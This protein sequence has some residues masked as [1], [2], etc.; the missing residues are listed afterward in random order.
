MYLQTNL[1]HKYLSSLENCKWNFRWFQDQGE[2]TVFANFCNLLPFKCFWQCP[3]VGEGVIKHRTF[4]S[5]HF[6]CK[7]SQKQ[8]LD[9]T[10]CDRRR[11]KEGWW[12]PELGFCDAETAFRSSAGK[13]G[14]VPGHWILRK[15][16]KIN[17][18]VLMI[19]DAK[20]SLFCGI[21]KW[22]TIMVILGWQL[23]FVGFSWT[24][25]CRWLERVR[26]SKCGVPGGKRYR[27]YGE[28]HNLFSTFWWP[29]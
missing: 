2:V 19:L 18:F 6:S 25:H 10:T 17:C 1:A 27:N 20:V 5:K 22:S 4:L 9:F 3:W 14:F 29:C 28:K 7:R 11:Y 8:C 23:W 16:S 24:T 12:E 26:S 15:L 21:S 13:V